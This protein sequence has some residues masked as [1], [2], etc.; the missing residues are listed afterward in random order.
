MKNPAWRHAAAAAIAFIGMI[1]WLE[2]AAGIELILFPTLAALTWE[3]FRHPHGRWA[4]APLHIVLIPGITAC[5]GIAISHMMNYGMAAVLLDAGLAITI[6]RI[7]RS[8]V[9]PAIAVALLPIF[10]H[11]TN[12]LYPVTITLGTGLLVGCSL[13]VRNLPGRDMPESRQDRA[14]CC[15]SLLESSPT[16]DCAMPALGATLA[17][18]AF[19]AHAG[20]ERL[21]LYPPLAVMGFE[22]FTRPSACPWAIHPWK[23]PVASTAS[24]LG[25]G[26]LVTLFGPGVLAATGVMIL[27]LATLRGLDL[28]APPVLAVGLLPL[29][30]PHVN[31]GS[32]A[33]VA[34]GTTLL[35]I[36]FKAWRLLITAADHACG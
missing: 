35:A 7:T 17:A 19:L 12:W 1:A 36:A 31:L 6:V 26:I 2:K 25:G 30:I 14:N 16:R 11:V 33:A 28:D 20:G 22:M 23:L 21:I 3:V 8:P 34:L 18:L 13:L 32:V 15:G 4:S 24:A 29:V 10:L 27:G 5:L 9:S